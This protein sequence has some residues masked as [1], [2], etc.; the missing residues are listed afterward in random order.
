MRQNRSQTTSREIWITTMNSKRVSS[1]RL[2][3]APDLCSRDYRSR[4]KR[5]GLRSPVRPRRNAA[6]LTGPR[7]QEKEG[8][9][10][11]SERYVS[12][13]AR[14]D[15]ANQTFD[16]IIVGGGSA[17]AVL[18]ARLSADAQRRVRLLEAVPNF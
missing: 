13:R 11:I 14:T 18:A 2:T 7:S 9:M 4:G 17:G 15:A 10:K 1:M 5:K 6:C 12:A 8:I 3:R 16:I